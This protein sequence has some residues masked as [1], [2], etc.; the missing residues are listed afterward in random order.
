MHVY[1]FLLDHRLEVEDVYIESAEVMMNPW[2]G[3][4]YYAAPGFEAYVRM[5]KY[6]A[7]LPGYE[8][9]FNAASTRDYM[10]YNVKPRAKASTVYRLVDRD[11]VQAMLRGPDR[12]DLGS[13][14]HAI[15]AAH[16]WGDYYTIDGRSVIA[17]T[18]VT[19]AR[20][21]KRTEK[22]WEDTSVTF[23]LDQRQLKSVE[24]EVYGTHE[25]T[26]DFYWNLDLYA[27]D[28]PRDRAKHHLGSF[29]VSRGWQTI[30]IDVPQGMT[31]VGLNKLGFKTAAFQPLVVCPSNVAELECSQ[32]RLALPP[33]HPDIAAP[34]RV[35][36]A[37]GAPRPVPM[38][39]SLFAGT[40]ALHY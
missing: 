15:Y 13:V 21:T 33:Q 16:G 2:D 1:S 40:L 27:Y 26:L 9:V 4:F 12:I 14:D 6:Q 8:V 5:Q 11:A 38:R 7:R 17:A 10:K 36:R 22:P 30:R 23:F 3:P 28:R 24:L 29:R 34:L 19:N 31:R 35:L 39:A 18:D 32:T 20:Y 37:D 25:T